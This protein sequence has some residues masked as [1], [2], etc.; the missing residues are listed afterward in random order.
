MLNNA[1][2]LLLGAGLMA[3][4][5]LTAAFAERIRNSRQLETK[6]SA[7][8][9]QERRAP[10]PS[11]I[12]IADTHEMP[13]SPTITRTPTRPP[14]PSDAPEM[15]RSP[16]VTRAPRAARA[17]TPNLADD[18]IAALVAT[19]YKRPIATQATWACEEAERVTIELWTAAA[20]RRCG[21]GNLS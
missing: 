11:I 4:G 20:L 2:F 14:T 17:A 15:P 3:I 9:E 13:R 8:R 19:G 5:V 21:Q 18:V 6:H 1:L 7:T 16:T 12:T 10:R